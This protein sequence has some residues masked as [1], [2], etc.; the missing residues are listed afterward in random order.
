MVLS[1]RQ[2]D[3]KSDRLVAVTLDPNTITSTNP[4][5]VHE[6][7]IAIYDLVEENVFAPARVKSTG[8]YALHVSI[9]GNY[10]L[11]DVRHPDT[12]EP[13]AAHYLS[14]TPFRHL[15]R[16]Y[17]R[18]RESYYDAI[19]TGSTYQIETVD[20]ARRGLHNEA[21][22]LLRTRLDN[23][24]VM[25]LNTARRLFTL[26]C[27]VQPF[28]SRIDERESDLPTVLFVCSMNSVRSP[29]AA[30][31][32]RKHFPGRLIVRSAGVRSGKADGFVEEVMEEIGI[33]MS[34]H[35][36][37]TMDELAANH[38]D[39]VITLSTDASE[40]FKRHGIEAG[41]IEHWPMPDPTET[42]GNRESVL[43]AYRSL[44][45]TLQKRVRERCEKLVAQAKVA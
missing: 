14:L 8:P 12:Y 2:L 29:I 15:I 19:K 20:M 23:K 5:E 1:P 45:D 40:A 42:E 43:S 24:L 39:L 41:A 44:R 32:A 25:D 36:P 27:A 17:F 11:L 18:I 37:H 13:I 31:L 33:D 28:A 6:W 4:D 7:R 34:V 26:I 35:T 3:Q 22:E 38:F 9:T 30:A 16:D 10:I 21:A